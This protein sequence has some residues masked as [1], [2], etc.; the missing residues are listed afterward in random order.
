MS[1]IILAQAHQ[2]LQEV[3]RCVDA[4]HNNKFDLFFCFIQICKIEQNRN[5][6]AE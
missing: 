4:V 6:I 1:C 5:C 2:I 3:Q